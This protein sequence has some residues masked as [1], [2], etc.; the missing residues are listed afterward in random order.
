MVFTS[1]RS[2]FPMGTGD[3][4]TEQMQSLRIPEGKVR[5]NRYRT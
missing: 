3:M 4:L 5:A 1:T 2:E